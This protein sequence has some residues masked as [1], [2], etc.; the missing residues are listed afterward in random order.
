MAIGVIGFA[1]GVDDFEGEVYKS[2]TDSLV[3]QSD[4]SAGNAI[5]V[6]GMGGRSTG[7]SRDL[8]RGGKKRL[9]SGIASRSGS[10]EESCLYVVA[11]TLR[12]SSMDVSRDEGAVGATIRPP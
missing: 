10:A 4:A 8:H 9:L 11:G 3:A 7:E 1:I 5:G 2:L 12:A 6:G